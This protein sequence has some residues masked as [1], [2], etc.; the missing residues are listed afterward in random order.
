MDRTYTELMRQARDMETQAW[1]QAYSG[2]YDAA[3]MLFV[4]AHTLWATVA[5]STS[6]VRAIRIEVAIAKTLQWQ[7]ELGAAQRILVRALWDAHIA[8]ID[9]L[10]TLILVSL[11]D[12]AV[13]AEDYRFAHKLL[14]E[15][16]PQ[17]TGDPLFVSGQLEILAL[18]YFG[19]R[20]PTRAV[21]VFGSA[22]TAH[23]EITI[24]PTIPAVV[25]RRQQFHNAAQQLLGNSEYEARLNQGKRMALADA[26][27]YALSH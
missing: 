12:I 2:N 17:S 20:D 5:N 9:R 25:A 13:A 22:I 16:L 6:R 27:G 26:V 11:A 21:V 10:I 8:D 7:G 3:H 24:G 4:K 15:T 14:E 19:E 1:V 18:A 23:D